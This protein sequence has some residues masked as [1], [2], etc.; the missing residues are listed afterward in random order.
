MIAV[1]MHNKAVDLKYCALSPGELAK[2][3]SGFIQTPQIR[4]C[5][6]SQQTGLSCPIV[7]FVHCAKAPGWGDE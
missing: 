7:K 5:P 6:R 2:T 4:I 1:K 3:I